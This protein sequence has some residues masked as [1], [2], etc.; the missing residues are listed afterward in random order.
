MT[1]KIVTVPF[2]EWDIVEDD[3]GR[4][5]KGWKF[6]WSAGE[7]TVKVERKLW[8]GAR[9]M[10][11]EDNFVFE[12]GGSGA[13]FI[14]KL[15]VRRNRAE[16]HLDGNDKLDKSPAGLATLVSEVEGCM[17]VIEVL[18]SAGKLN[19]RSGVLVGELKFATP[20]R[21]LW[22]LFEGLEA[23]VSMD[24]EKKVIAKQLVGDNG[25]RLE[26]LRGFA[27]GVRGNIEGIREVLE[28]RLGR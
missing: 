4:G 8:V 15:D 27:E 13:S 1:E 7:W 9:G 11:E 24:G 19:S 10:L 17:G 12:S 16:F 14:M 23:R 20:T 25:E 18:A 26:Q 6:A 28:K 5:D 2:D 3:F 22:R 21:F